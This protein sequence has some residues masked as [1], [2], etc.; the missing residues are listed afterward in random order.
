M[1]PT[2]HCG[3]RSAIFYQEPDAG[4]AYGPLRWTAG[5]LT[6]TLPLGTDAGAVRTHPQD[7]KAQDENNMARS[8]GLERSR[9][10][11][12]KLSQ[13]DVGQGSSGSG[14][15]GKAEDL[16]R[17]GWPETAVNN[18]GSGNLFLQLAKVDPGPGKEAHRGRQVWVFD[19]H[20]QVWGIFLATR[21]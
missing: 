13:V 15:W 21:L 2:G 3:F 5:V 10:A 19:I 6:A 1:I 17:S 7:L 18:V 8:S 14:L 4:L 16:H 20:V 11:L 9:A 12:K